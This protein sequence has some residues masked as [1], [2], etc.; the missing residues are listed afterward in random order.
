MPETSSIKQTILGSTPIYV[1]HENALESKYVEGLNKNQKLA[2]QT[3]INSKFSVIQGPPGT[4]KT[5][6][7]V[8]LILAL[9]ESDPKAKFLVC[10]DSNQSVNNLC[11]KFIEE[12]RSFGLLD[13]IKFTR[14]LSVHAYFSN[15]QIHHL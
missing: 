7:I 4:G 2:I 1:N 6:T 5:H 13:Q 15:Q 12:L 14:F 10:G 3:A 11:M 8:R 9:L